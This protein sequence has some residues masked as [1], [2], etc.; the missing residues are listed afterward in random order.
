[1]FTQRSFASSSSL[2]ERNLAFSFPAVCIILFVLVIKATIKSCFTALDC[3][4][5]HE[6]KNIWDKDNFVHFKYVN[7][8]NI[9]LNKSK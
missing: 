6:I 7:K 8:K 9:Y 3:L 1:M 2:L 5:N 4:K